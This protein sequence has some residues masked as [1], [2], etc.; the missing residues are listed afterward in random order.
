VHRLHPGR[1]LLVI[2]VR[3]ERQPVPHA[4]GGLARRTD[5]DGERLREALGVSR[6]QAGG[7]D[8]LLRPDAGAL[9]GLQ[10][11]VGDHGVDH[12]AGG[13]DPVRADLHADRVAEGRP[14]VDA[15]KDLAHRHHLRSSGSTSEP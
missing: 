15:G 7:Q 3:L 11:L 5:G 14:V 10:P 12:D 2:G 4:V 6:M 1:E 13:L 8:D 9:E